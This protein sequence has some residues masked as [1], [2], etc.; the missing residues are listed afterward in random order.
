M[1]PNVALCPKERFLP[2]LCPRAGQGWCHHPCSR[3]GF[4]LCPGPGAGGAAPVSQGG[5][6]SLQP[7]GSGRRGHWPGFGE[8]TP[9]ISLL[10]SLWRCLPAHQGQTCV[11][12]HP[13]A[14]TQFQQLFPAF[15]TAAGARLPGLGNL[16]CVIS[17]SFL[18][19]SS[20]IS[21]VLIPFFNKHGFHP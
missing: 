17:N 4:G 7:Q 11:Q 12:P 10:P 19:L 2:W 18:C 15:P 21:P 13:A 9:F 6:V 20:W 3:T 16:S 8:F 14:P 5:A 1:A